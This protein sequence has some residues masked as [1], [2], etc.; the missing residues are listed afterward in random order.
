MGEAATAVSDEVFS[1]LA[2]NL[3]HVLEARALLCVIAPEDVQGEAVVERG[4]TVRGD[5]DAAGWQGPVTT[6][7][8]SRRVGQQVETPITP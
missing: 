4:G 5:P 7:D 2:E 8:A 1:A 3:G 6:D